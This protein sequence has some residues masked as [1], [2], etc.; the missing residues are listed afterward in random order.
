MAF[1]GLHKGARPL[2]ALEGQK[3]HLKK[4]A[5]PDVTSPTANRLQHPKKDE[6]HPPTQTTA[7]THSSMRSN[8]CFAF[9]KCAGAHRNC[10]S[11]P[12]QPCVM[13]PWCCNCACFPLHGAH[14]LQTAQC[15][16]T[17]RAPKHYSTLPKHSQ[18]VFLVHL[19]VEMCPWGSPGQPRRWKGPMPAKTQLWPRYVR[20][21]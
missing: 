11:W 16:G 3:P 7:R 8:K 4:T 2:E 14:V 6:T 5:W 13:P 10:C 19:T 17:A 1:A 21:F 9:C 18:K 20:S 12:V 15:L